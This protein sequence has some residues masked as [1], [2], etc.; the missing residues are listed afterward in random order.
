MLAKRAA[1]GARAAGQAR[2]AARLAPVRAPL[3]RS[4]SSARRP[5]QRWRAAAAEVRVLEG[6]RC[7]RARAWRDKQRSRPRPCAR[8]FK[9]RWVCRTL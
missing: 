8:Q 1:T 5:A 7:T 3:V 6:V 2:P 9:W 4:A